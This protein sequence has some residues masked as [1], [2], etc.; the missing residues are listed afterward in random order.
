MRWERSAP[1]RWPLPAS[2]TRSVFPMP[3]RC[4]S[5]SLTRRAIS[6]PVA[7]RWRS[8]RRRRWRRWTGA[9]ARRPPWPIWPNCW[10]RRRPQA[11]RLLLR[12]S[13]LRH[14]G[15][16]PPGLGAIL[17]IRVIAGRIVT[18]L[19]GRRR[20]RLLHLLLR[21][22]RHRLLDHR[23]R[24][25][26]VIGIIRIAAVI[27]RPPGIVES[28]P[29]TPAP[30]T[31]MPAAS[32]PA[33]A[34]IASAVIASTAMPAPVP[35]GGGGRGGDRGGG[36]GDQRETTQAVF[37]DKVDHGKVLGLRFY[38]IYGVWGGRKNVKILHFF[39]VA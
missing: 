11:T 32:V 21:D 2:S 18:V 25:I 34:V 26:G 16:R 12:R 3:P 28:D 6:R 10:P 24:R 5:G 35:L 14:R 19:I 4:W 7:D 20:R 37:A 17:H 9:A 29:D 22:D 15:H 23:H 38:P 39:V 27:A 36:G 31:T 8:S 1:A 30:A 33:S 13:R